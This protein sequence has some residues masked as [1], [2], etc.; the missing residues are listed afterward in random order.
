MKCPRCKGTGKV[1]DLPKTMGD[2][3]LMLRDAKGVTSKVVEDAVGIAHSTLWRMER[4]KQSG[5]SYAE[6]AK[7]AAY[8]DVT[9]DDLVGKQ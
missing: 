3:L 1:S 8:Y 6:L 5:G 4:G 7:L 9:I 2:R